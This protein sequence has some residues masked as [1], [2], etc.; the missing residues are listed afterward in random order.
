MCFS[1][2]KLWIKIAKNGPYKVF[3]DFNSNLVYAL[4][5]KMTKHGECCLFVLWEKL[6]Y[7]LL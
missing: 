7:G 4:H 6:V 5:T 1:I 3:M 2:V